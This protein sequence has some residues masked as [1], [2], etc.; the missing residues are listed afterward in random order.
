MLTFDWYITDGKFLEIG[1]EFHTKIQNEEKNLI[2]DSDFVQYDAFNILNIVLF[3]QIEGFF[4]IKITVLNSDEFLININDLAGSIGFLMIFSAAFFSWLLDRES[5]L[6]FYFFDFFEFIV[7]LFEF[8]NGIK[9]PISWP[10]F[11]L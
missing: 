7:F 9:S 1:A 10:E 8:L 5:F 4:S 6:Y 11:S 3:H 2:A